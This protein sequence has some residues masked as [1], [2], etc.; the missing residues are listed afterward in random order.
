MARR[1]RGKEQGLVLRVSTR[2][3]I[4]VTIQRGASGHR[5]DI[6]IAL[7]PA[8]GRECLFALIKSLAKLKYEAGTNLAEAIWHVHG[9]FSGLGATVNG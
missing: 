8:P 2:F 5:N 4:S 3:S 9:R 1:S 6:H 7:S